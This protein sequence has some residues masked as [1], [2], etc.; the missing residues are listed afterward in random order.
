MNILPIK[1][2]EGLFIIQY[3]ISSSYFFKQGPSLPISLAPKIDSGTTL[4]SAAVFSLQKRL[5]AATTTTT[6]TIDTLLY[7][8]DL[9]EKRCLIA[10]SL[11]NFNI[12]IASSSSSASAFSTTNTYLICEHFVASWKYLEDYQNVLFR[13]HTE[14]NEETCKGLF[15]RFPIPN[16]NLLTLNC[17]SCNAPI[18]IE[19]FSDLDVKKINENMIWNFWRIYPENPYYIGW[20]PEE[21]LLDIFSF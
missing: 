13:D 12:W 18:D 6:T 19:W 8:H 3:K 2:T 21:V 9:N 17:F 10:Q 15:V 14:H 11:R 16:S 7:C 1:I 4:I 5:D 20:I